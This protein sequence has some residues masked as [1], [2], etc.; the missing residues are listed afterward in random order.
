MP[1]EAMFLLQV[2]CTQTSI[3]LK[4]LKETNAAER[5]SLCFQSTFTQRKHKEQRHHF[6]LGKEDKEGE[7]ET[8]L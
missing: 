5:G 3:V 8:P 7:L 1:V 6:S 4:S 2:L